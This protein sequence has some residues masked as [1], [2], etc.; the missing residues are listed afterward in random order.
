M[1]QDLLKLPKPFRLKVQSELEAGERVHYAARPDWRPELG[2][3]IIVFLFG[4]GWS[5]V[6][7][8]LT[9]GLLLDMA[10]LIEMGT[11]GLPSSMWGSAGLALFMMPFVIIGG[12]VMSVP[13]YGIS[14]SRRTVHVVTDRRILNVITG[15]TGAADS[16]PLQH[17][18]S[19]R[20]KDHKSGTGNIAIC[21]G[22][23]KD[24]DGD[25]RALVLDWYGIPDAKKAEKLILARPS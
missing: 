14:Q 21:Y 15:K 18:L 19:V 24:S 16:Y 13:F 8:P 17:V 11:K 3:Y 25:T 23:G 6:V 2:K 4:A 12:L 7:F 22:I 9:A 5:A 1:S 20:R 10:G